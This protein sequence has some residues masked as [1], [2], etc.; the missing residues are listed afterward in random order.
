MPQY[1]FRVCNGRYSGSSDVG[2]DSSDR[3][4][5]WAETTRV[6]GDLARG[7]IS[8]LGENAAWHM[9]LLNEAKQPVFRI[10]LVAET[11]L[12]ADVEGKD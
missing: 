4:A 1:F 10:R 3:D 6:C 11:L 8:A 2:F 5:A 9:E 7:V 12:P